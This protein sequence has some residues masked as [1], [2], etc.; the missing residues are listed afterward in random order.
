MGPRATRPV[1]AGSATTAAMRVNRDRSRPTSHRRGYRPGMT[2]PDDDHTEPARLTDV[3]RTNTPG[4]AG[5]ATA[6]ALQQPE[7]AR[8]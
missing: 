8:S 7:W 3:I 4:L 1:T 2:E 5:G 6:N